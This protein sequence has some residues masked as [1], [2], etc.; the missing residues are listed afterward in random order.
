MTVASAVSVIGRRAQAQQ[1][2]FRAG[3]DIVEVEVITRDKAGRFVSDLTLEDFELR[4]DGK[5]FPVQQVYVRTGSTAPAARVAASPDAGRSPRL[6][7]GLR[8]CPP[9]ASGFKRTQSA[10]LALFQNQ[11]HDGDIGGVVANGHMVNGRLTSDRAELIKAV[12]DA[13]PNGQVMAAQLDERMWPRLNEIEA[14]R[15]N[16][17]DDKE[18]MDMATARGCAEQKG[19]CDGPAGDDVVRSMLFGKAAQFASHVRVEAA[20]TLGMLRS[21][22]T[23]L[24]RIDGPKNVLLMSEGFI[25]EETW[26]DVQ[27]AIAG[28]AR[29]NTRIY[30]LDARGIGRG[31]ASVDNAAPTETMTRMFEQMDPAADSINSLAVDTGGFV[32]R[33]ANQFDSAIAQIADDAGNYYVLG[34]LP[35]TPADRKFHKI[36]V[37]V[38]RPGVSVRSR[39]GYYRNAAGGAP[40]ATEVRLKPDTTAATDVRLKPDATDASTAAPWC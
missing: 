20:K 31:M 18:M 5:P 37:R 9:H 1:P 25:S 14:V 11:L 7:R 22:L 32:V 40:A 39:R 29:A 28:A 30:A 36:S 23:G 6:R 17:N 2:L 3:T 27:E 24:G 35:P 15:I 10:A 34:Y 4:E 12:K 26:P 13:K 8:R 33:N 38:K 16:V 19:V 21:V